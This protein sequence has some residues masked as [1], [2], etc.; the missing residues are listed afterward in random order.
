M[1]FDTQQSASFVTQ[2]GSSR[3]PVDC[4]D[5]ALLH[6][7]RMTCGGVGNKAFKLSSLLADVGPDDRVMSFGGAWSNHLHALAY[8]CHR[9]GVASVGV[10]RAGEPTDNL[11]Q[12][13]MRRY[14]MQLHHVSREE[15]RRRDDADYCQSLC[16]QLGCTM[17][18]P[19][20][21]SD[22]AAVEGCRNLGSIIQSLDYQP[23]VVVLPVGTGAT[24]AGVINAVDADTRVIGL[25]VVRDD[26]V[27]ANI[28]RWIGASAGSC[29][30]T[31][32][33]RPGYGKVDRALLE[34][35]VDFHSQTQIVLD[36]VYTGKALMH[37]FSSEFRARLPAVSRVLF[38]H[39]GG[40]MG[41]FGYL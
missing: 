34:F 1:F 9:Q 3:Y 6:T 36:P 17:W 23:T 10:I 8:L 27:K 13:S 26:K 4:V 32:P 11:L 18:L 35:I 24:M 21:G 39:T 12:R 38:L 40:L 25:P 33:L 14:G 15:Y 22:N 29:T 20:G 28:D 30:L 2:L 16:R 5:I 37:C 31:A 7:E 41:N 19:E